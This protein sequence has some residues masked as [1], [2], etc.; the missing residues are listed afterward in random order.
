MMECSIITDGNIDEQI[1]KL[2]DKMAKQQN[3]HME[4]FFRKVET[5][6]GTLSSE[7]DNVKVK[8]QS[9]QDN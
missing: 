7:I 8:V 9:V 1:D 5:S 4:A 3:T 6:I 2:F